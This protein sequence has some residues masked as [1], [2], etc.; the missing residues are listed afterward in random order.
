MSDPVHCHGV[1]ASLLDAAASADTRPRV[2]E[3]VGFEYG[4]AEVGQVW[5][6]EDVEDGGT[7]VRESLE[8]G[9][10]D[11]AVEGMVGSCRRVDVGMC[12][13]IGIC[14]W[15]GVFWSREIGAE[16][17]H[18]FLVFGRCECDFTLGRWN[19]SSGW[20]CGDGGRWCGGCCSGVR[21]D[22]CW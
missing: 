19:G 9:H 11:R 4:S 2:R 16:K 7:E 5:V 15:T 17:G 18:D 21:M 13:G 1:Y 8:G 3:L 6:A 10:G 20:I 22:V 12:E 14:G